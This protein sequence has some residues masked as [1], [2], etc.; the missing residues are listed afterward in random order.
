[1]LVKWEELVLGGVW[2]QEGRERPRPCPAHNCLLL[3]QIREVTVI[4]NMNIY[5]KIHRKNPKFK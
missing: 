2:E 1:M 5:V 4:F 3:L